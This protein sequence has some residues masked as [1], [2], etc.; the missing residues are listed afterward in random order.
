ML[1]FDSP[2]DEANF[3]AQSKARALFE[4]KR[5]EHELE[6]LKSSLGYTQADLDS[7]AKEGA[8]PDIDQKTYIERLLAEQAY[9]KLFKKF[10]YVRYLH[11]IRLWKEIHQIE[12]A[13]LKHRLWWVLHNCFAHILIGLA[14]CRTTFKLHDW[15]SQRLN[16]PWRNDK[17]HELEDVSSAAEI[18]ETAVK[19]EWRAF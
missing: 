14:P 4:I 9:G 12:R 6:N 5:R 16:Q 15:T 1:F 3:W 7:L 19:A 2:Q 11:R 8:V 18:K 10:S 13:G 17:F